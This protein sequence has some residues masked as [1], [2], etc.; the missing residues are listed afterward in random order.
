MTIYERAL[1][2][3]QIILAISFG[4]GYKTRISALLSWILYLSLTL[5]KTWLSYI[6]DRYIHY[7]LFYSIFLPFH[8]EH[9]TV[10]SLATIFAKLQILWIYLD[11]GL[12]KYLDNGWSVH[13]SPLPALDTYARHTCVSRYLYA[14][15]T[16]VG[17]RYLTPTVVYV[18]LAVVPLALLASYYRNI[19]FLK[20]VIA[21]ICSLH[22]GIALTI[23]N[24][25]LL[26]SAACVSWWLFYHPRSHTSSNL[27]K[28]YLQLCCIVP[29]V[30]GSIWFEQYSNECTQSMEHIWSTL[31]HN[32]WNV[33][34]GAEEYVTWE[35]CV[36]K[37]QNGTIVE[38]W[39]NS[40]NVSWA[41]P[42]TKQHDLIAHTTTTR[43]GRW[44]SYPYLADFE[45]EQEEF[46]T[47]NYLCKQWNMEHEV[48]LEKFNFFMLQADVLPN[49]GFSSTRKRLIHS[50]VCQNEFYLK[51]DNSVLSDL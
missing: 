8:A 33:F 19:T 32:R 47:W 9:K 18:E 27:S 11:A 49:M 10:V 23:K 2:A 22:I 41:M 51:E 37:L 24:T 1:L 40:Y 43:K 14:A 45:S 25:Y 4:L 44:R 28:S 46:L 38:L 35:I 20:F 34:T 42:G 48:S 31:L 30:V 16:P 36:G 17:L 13:A 3:V 26:S 39:S 29:F 21:L 5:R 50:H 15:L 6:L 7:L 12:G